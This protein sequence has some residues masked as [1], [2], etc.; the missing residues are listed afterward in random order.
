MT[1]DNVFIT[2]GRYLYRRPRAGI[3]PPPPPPVRGTIRIYRYRT[4]RKWVFKRPALSSRRI[5]G[6]NHGGVAYLFISLHCNNDKLLSSWPRPTIKIPSNPARS[7][8][9]SSRTNV[10][11]I[12]III[13]R[14]GFLRVFNT[15]PP[16]PR[17]HPFLKKKKKHSVQDG[18]FR[19][20]VSPARDSRINIYYFVLHRNRRKRVVENLNF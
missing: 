15:P 9:K 12:I 17:A 1:Y 8:I 4:P 13:P 10:I 3:P 18:P 11:I 6:A 14:L 20:D 19:G 2:D 5:T 16:F 7:L